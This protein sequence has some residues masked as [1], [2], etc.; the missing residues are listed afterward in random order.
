MCIVVIL[1]KA[2]NLVLAMQKILRFAQN[3]KIDCR[4]ATFLCL[5]LFDELC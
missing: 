3:D 5:A 2:K 1:S 4:E